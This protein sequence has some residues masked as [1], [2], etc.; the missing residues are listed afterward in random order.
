[1]VKQHQLQRVA[2]GIEMR[3][4]GQATVIRISLPA[5]PPPE[6]AFQSDWYW[7]E[8]LP[9]AAR[10]VF[11]KLS[12]ARKSLV[13]VVEITLSASAL[14]HVN[15]TLE[16]NTF[17]AVLDNYVEKNGLKRESGTAE[18]LETL[19]KPGQTKEAAFV[20]SM[21][22]IGFSENDA[23]ISFYRLPP[24]AELQAGNDPARLRVTALVRVDISTA[25][26]QLFCRDVRLN[27]GIES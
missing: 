21:T 12:A 6:E 22:F 15:E 11:G 8:R 25:L 10:F 24:G 16:A 14:K 13:G 9:G 5:L 4:E 19:I 20:A 17:L 3:R 1:M 26:L 7:S 2:H 18:E 23:A 27:L